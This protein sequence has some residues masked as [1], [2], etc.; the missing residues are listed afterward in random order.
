M[1]QLV[2]RLRRAV[3]NP[4]L[5]LH[6]R[7]RRSRR[8][9][10]TLVREPGADALVGELRAVPHHRGVHVGRF[11]IALLTDDVLDDDGEAVLLIG[12]RREIGRQ[13]LRQHGKD[14]GRRVHRRRVLRRVTID[15]RS[16][17]HRGIDVGDGDED[18]HVAVRRRLGDRQLIEVARLVVVDRAPRASAKVARGA[19]GRLRRSAEGG[20]FG[21]RARRKVGVETAGAHGGDGYRAQLVALG[22]DRS[23]RAVSA[24]T[25]ESIDAAKS[26]TS[27]STWRWCVRK[28][29]MHTRP[30]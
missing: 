21:E 1:T 26:S 30:R 28:L 20:H 13:L 16:F 9:Q 11:Q 23:E 3:L 29:R 6:F 14:D 18:L 15:C 25:I 19:P 24:A 5:F 12:E 22:H 27:A 8:R 10:R 4:E 2:E 7:H 17:V